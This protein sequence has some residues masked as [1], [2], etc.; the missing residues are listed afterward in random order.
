MIRLWIVVFALTLASW[1]VLKVIRKPVNLFLVFGFW[2]I[3]I[4]G[5]MGLIYGISVLLAQNSPI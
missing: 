2:I 1:L 4:W 3:A 5:T